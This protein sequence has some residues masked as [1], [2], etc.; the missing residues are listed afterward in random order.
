[1]HRFV[2]YW[3]VSMVRLMSQRT[4]SLYFEGILSELRKLFALHEKHSLAYIC[5]L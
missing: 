5:P 2:V 3:R 4:G 1:M